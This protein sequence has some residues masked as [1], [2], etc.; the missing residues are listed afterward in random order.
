MILE[1][2]T[3]RDKADVLIRRYCASNILCF[4][5]CK[6][7]FF[8]FLFIAL[9]CN[10]FT[11]V[12]LCIYFNLFRCLFFLNEV[13]KCPYIWLVLHLGIDYWSMHV[14]TKHIPLLQSYHPSYSVV[15]NEIID[16]VMVIEEHTRA[17]S[18]NINLSNTV[19]RSHSAFSAA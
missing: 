5:R 17:C 11:M 6:C 14:H 15:C 8:H 4:I 18:S 1:T 10:Y 3:L 13:D 19:V 12:H 16:H 7:L 9:G 2:H